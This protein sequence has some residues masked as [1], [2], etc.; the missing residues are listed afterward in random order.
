MFWYG[1][2][3]AADLMQE[4]IG[5]TTVLGRDNTLRVA[6]DGDAVK[7]EQDVITF[8]ALDPTLTFDMA[9]VRLFRGFVDNAAA[10]ARFSDKAFM[11]DKEDLQKTKP[12]LHALFMAIEGARVEFAYTEIYPGSGKNVAQLSEVLFAQGNFMQ[13]SDYWPTAIGIFARNRMHGVYNTYTCNRVAQH[14]NRGQIMAWVD[15]LAG[16]TTTAQSFALAERIY[17]DNKKEKPEKP[18]SDN[19]NTAGI[20][21]ADLVMQAIQLAQGDIEDVADDNKPY[22]PWRTDYDA[23]HH[24]TNAGWCPD[25]TPYL[26]AQCAMGAELATA[27][28]KLELLIQ[29]TKKITYA[30]HKERG[31]LDSRR[32]VAAYQ[33]DPHV[34]KVKHDASDLDTAVAVSVDL[35]R[36]MIGNKAYNA[37]MGAVVLSE[38]LNKIG[39][40]FEVTGFDCEYTFPKSLARNYTKAHA[41]IEAL[42]THQFKRFNDRFFDARQYYGRIASLEG[43]GCNNADGE[44]IAIAGDSL[45]KRPEKRKILFVLSDGLPHANGNLG[46]QYVFLKKTVQRLEKHMEVVGIGI[47]SDAVKS[48]YAKNIVLH[49]SN[50][51]PT[52]MLALLKEKLLPKNAAH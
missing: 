34:F 16:F 24:W 29:S 38:L 51:L 47:E 35:S 37:F 33:D 6:F 17:K 13:E 44:S 23:I 30:T 12:Q 20:T 15:E 19:A 36:S 10:I 11:Q 50:N 31:R 26:N 32:L 25:V 27:K 9:T 7:A 8:P 45:M 18:D 28:R 48:F 3:T 21:N 49:N 42:R 2:T 22:I 5:T 39:V 40:P 41:R 43:S 1:K 4:M 14:V 52:T 46:R